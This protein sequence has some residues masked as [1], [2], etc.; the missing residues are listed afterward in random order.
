MLQIQIRYE[1]IE[2]SSF[3]HLVLLLSSIVLGRTASILYL[4]F[5]LC[6]IKTVN[7]LDEVVRRI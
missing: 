5:T 2:M 1:G 4:V 7:F 3:Y 6:P